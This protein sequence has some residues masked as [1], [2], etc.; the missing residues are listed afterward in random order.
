[1]R[2][3]RKLPPIA[4][5]VALLAVVVQAAAGELPGRSPDA[6]AKPSGTAGGV[7]GSYTV[8]LLTGDR[9]T[10]ASAGAL[11]GAVHPAKGREKM[12]FL[13]RR[14][15]GHLYVV[16]Q[17]AQ[18][19]VAA[20]RLDQRLFDVT[21][22]VRLGYHDA[23][24]DTLPLLVTYR[25]GAARA[26]GVALART[27]ATVT[28]ELPGIGAAA[29]TADKATMPALWTVAASNGGV[30]KLWLDGKRRISLD[31]SVAQIGAPAAW[32]AGYTGSGVTV[33]VL[34]TGVDAA[35]PDLA[36]R[37]AQQR[38]FTGAAD[39]GD[40][41]GHGTHVA[42]TVAGSG[43]ASSGRYRGVAPEATL[44]SGKV[45]ESEFCAESAML[46]GLEWAA[47]EA[48][49]DVVNV[50][51]GGPDGPEID[52]LEEAVNVL[53]A[54]HGT[55]FVVAAG[56]EGASVSSPGSADSALTV[57]AVDRSD[58]IATFSARGPR[59]GDEAIK[60]DVTAPGVDIVAARAEGTGAGVPAGDAYT[61]MSGTSMATPHVA[62][63]AALLAQQHPD[64]TAGRLKATLLGSAQ[65]AAEATAFE[66]GAGRVDLARAVTQAL[67]SDPT[68]LSYGRVAWPHDD[69]QPATK[70]V[71][72]GNDGSADAVLDLALQ[73]TGADGAPAPDGMFTLDTSRLTV[74][75][76]GV[77]QVKLTADTT[78][79]A[80]DGHYTG[81]LVATAGSARV[82]TPLA[83]HREPESYDLT[84][85][86][87]GDD[88]A[89]TRDYATTLVGLDRHWRTDVGVDSTVT[90]RVPK[91]RYGLSTA[92][93]RTRADGGF[94]VAVLARPV[95]D[96]RASTTLTLDA[97]LAKPVVMTV[98]DPSARSAVANIGYSFLTASDEHVFS[99]LAPDLDGLSTAQLG[100]AAPPTAFV[101]HLSA[102]WAKPDAEGRFDNS[103]YLYAV[104]EH[105]RGRFPTGFTRHYRARD[106]A[107]I[108]QEFSA[109]QPGLTG[110]RMVF[111]RFDHF[112]VP[113]AAVLPTSLPGRRVEYHNT[114]GV[115]WDSTLTLGV[116]DQDGVF[117]A[118]GEW[119]SPV[120][121]YQAGQRY[122]DRWVG[123]PFGPALLRVNGMPSEV[124]RTGDRISAFA[125]LHGDAG[126]HTGWL[127]N[128]TGRTALYRDGVLVAE[129]SWPAGEFTVPPDP[130]AYRLE[131][132]GTGGLGELSSEVSAVWT[133]NSA[134]TAAK[135][136]LPL[137]T[138]HF[139]PKMD[140][141]QSAASGQV[142]E[143]PVSVRRQPDAAQTDLAALTVDVS[144]D[145]G[146]TWQP[147]T[148]RRD[149]DRW[150]A[151]VTHPDVAGYVSLRATATDSAGNTV[152]QRIVRAY[153]IR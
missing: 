97:R 10:L 99:V 85:S 120:K 34:D 141:D 32:Q 143:F 131:V 123:A 35:H 5:V 72:Y 33:A 43:A 38:D 2:L 128:R 31:R 114:N 81:R 144:Y 94:E 1:M 106:L 147:V 82:V 109:P 11:S 59:V 124:T 50:S 4:L 76:G 61:S 7:R 96:L 151:T 90:L 112:A 65:P 58:R 133:F 137:S 42:S 86:H 145:D 67:T 83:L 51:I 107:G 93:Y 139:A 98:P 89:A 78:V 75:A 37:V 150:L 135:T 115:R 63:A 111:P 6:I 20:G 79:A 103:P 80:A 26:A 19:L 149:G 48:G 14:I 91:G 39:A 27:G 40:T 56:N 70:T 113:W 152:K 74:P 8:T 17:D 92:L 54:R 28:R 62:G 18:R 148:L 44:V 66:Q 153:R 142:V 15:D 110:E 13:T 60:P 69:D 130:A 52:P 122:R 125:G 9:V 126:G 53:T 21:E 117:A 127:F 88:G 16:P 64:W 22:L 41:Y 55:L 140:G 102:Q 119:A 116:R 129:N 12:A 47:A 100:A 136:A 57:G 3:T 23:A 36:G 87:L 132:S 121:R 73:I 101:A 49:A 24:L 146:G 71:T 30:E 95:L 104:G 134:H 138:V 25:A 84:L 77:A 46:A 118:R 45:C 29:I 108:H 105:T 68:S